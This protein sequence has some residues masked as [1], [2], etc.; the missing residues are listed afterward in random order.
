V[1]LNVKNEEAHRMARELAELTDSSITD[2]VTAALRSALQAAR[3]E[4]AEKQNRV[5]REL[6]EIAL[7]CASLA[8]I[9][10]RPPEEIIGYDDS[11]A[12]A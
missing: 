6:D 4:T 5:I 3:A 1:P 12:P 8:V 10:H 2:A 9:D 11:G 7:H